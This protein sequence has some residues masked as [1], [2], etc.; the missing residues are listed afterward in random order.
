MARADSILLQGELARIRGERRPVRRPAVAAG[1]GA[2]SGERT[3]LLAPR[4]RVGLMLSAGGAYVE[5]EAGVTVRPGVSPGLGIEAAW[6]TGR[7]LSAALGVRATASP[8]SIEEQGDTRSEGAA[9]Q[10]DLMG[11]IERGAGERWILRLAAGGAWLWGPADIVPFRYGNNGRVQPTVE[12][13]ALFRLTTSR[14]LAA[15]L[16]VQTSRLGNATLADPIREPGWA[17]RALLGVRYGR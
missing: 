9:T 7:S 4:I 17:N 10:L 13:G 6:I 3:P 1:A 11:A 5:D 8:V 15:S 2:D 16:T 12:L 14:P